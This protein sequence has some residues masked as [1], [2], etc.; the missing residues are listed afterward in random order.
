MKTN[1]GNGTNFYRA[2]ERE[3]NQL[4]LLTLFAG[5][6]GIFA[7]MK[8]R[9]ELAG[10][11]FAGLLLL[12]AVAA[13][14]WAGPPQIVVDVAR[15]RNLN[16]VEKGAEVEIYVTVP[17]QSLVYRQR[18]PKMF[19]SSAT[20]LLEIIKADGKPAFRELVALRPPPLTDTTLA[21]KNPQSFLKRIL[22]PDGKYTL[23]ATVRDQY[24]PATAAGTAIVERPLLLEA[25]TTAF[26]TDIVLLARPAVRNAGDDNFNRG[27]YRLSRTP[28][29]TYGRGAE[30]LYF[31][32]ELHNGLA[33]QSLRVQYRLAA[34]GSPAAAPVEISITPES[35]RPA[36]VLGQLP[37]LGLPTGEFA[38]LVDVFNGKKL[39]T[40]QRVS[41]QRTEA[42]FAPAA[43]PPMR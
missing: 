23:R 33:G 24:R 32:T 18:A 20:V 22:L 26:L 40:S 12:L 37:L 38:V 2:S 15:F 1:L 9:L 3:A 43:A 17:T 31:Y 16:K 28:G 5:H 39:L 19:Q 30:T 27:G 7:L 29:G 25:P 36:V 34:P 8:I 41:A 14:A 10:R 21:I 13:P 4:L 6:D 35:G 11:Y 42:D